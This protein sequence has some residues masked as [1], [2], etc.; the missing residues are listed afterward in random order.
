MLKKSI[1]NQRISWT[2]SLTTI[3]EFTQIAQKISQ[4]EVWPLLN[5]QEFSSCSEGYL[6]VIWKS[7]EP[8]ELLSRPAP[9]PSQKGMHRVLP[10]QSNST[11]D[12]KHF[13]RSK[14]ILVFFIFA[15]CRVRVNF[16]T[17]AKRTK[18]L[19][20]EKQQ[21]KVHAYGVWLD[22][23]HNGKQSVLGV[24]LYSRGI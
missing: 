16:N 5:K 11:E 15:S 23:V 18:L 24:L 19:W 1:V 2:L 3:Q 20:I 12:C 22:S 21:I 14:P 7:N 4:K 13:L 10:F 9:G 17:R 6:C 8:R